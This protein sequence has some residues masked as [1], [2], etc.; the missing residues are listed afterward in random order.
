MSDM[1]DFWRD[2]KGAGQESRSRNR[3]SSPTILKEA[4]IAFETKN[5]GTH[6]IVTHGDKVVDFWPGTGLWHAR[7][8]PKGR[9][10]FRLISYLNP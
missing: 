10:V 7:R 8:G 2:V 1:S 4:G 5:L 6:L 9:G 3:D